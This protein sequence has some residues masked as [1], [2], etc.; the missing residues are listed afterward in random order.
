[1]TRLQRQPSL[2]AP[3]VRT[4]TTKKLPSS[5][6]RDDGLNVGCTKYSGHRSCAARLSPHD[7]NWRA[8]LICRTTW[9]A[10]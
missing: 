5:A 8:T 1:M 7:M 10:I 4:L 9:D 6:A 3:D 2:G